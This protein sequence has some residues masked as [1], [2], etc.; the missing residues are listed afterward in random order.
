MTSSLRTL[1]VV[2]IVAG[3]LVAGMCSSKMG[4][5]GT[6]VASIALASPAMR[7][8]RHAEMYADLQRASALDAADPAIGELLGLFEISSER[9]EYLNEAAVHFRESVELRP[10][11][12]YTWANLAT[13]DYRL[14]ATH[15]EFRIALTRAVEL[16]PNE[17][18]VQRTVADLGLAVWAEVDSQ[19]RS[20]IEGAVERGMK[21]Q[22]REILQIAERRGRLAVACRHAVGPPRQTDTKWLQLCQS[23]EATS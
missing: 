20:T 14:G 5:A 22:P 19:M 15:E 12:P 16:G 11:S 13:A 10:M 6:T 7:N 9:S 1:V 18:E 2:P 8:A 17:P 21:S 4:I 23:T 3:L